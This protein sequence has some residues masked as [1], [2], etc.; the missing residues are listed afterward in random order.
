MAANP[1]YAIVSECLPYISQRLLSDTDPRTGSALRT[2]VFGKDKDR[3]DRVV[4]AERLEL[5]L[6]G[7]GSY[8]QAAGGMKAASALTSQ[9]IEAITE[10]ILDLLLRTTGGKKTP[11]QQLIIDEA[12]KLLGA[13]GRQTWALVRKQSGVLPS[14]RT[15]LGSIVDPLGIFRFSPL[16]L[17]DELDRRILESSLQLVS[18]LQKLVSENSS[19]GGMVEAR[20]DSPQQRELLSR[21]LAK[22]WARRRDL[23][24]LGSGIAAELVVQA[25]RRI[26][27]TPVTALSRSQSRLDLPSSRSP[28][29]LF[30]MTAVDEKKLSDDVNESPRL[31]KARNI[32]V[33]MRDDK[34]SPHA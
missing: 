6:Q 30:G 15:L 16:V 9:Q 5:L 20:L 12:S 21:L 14:G 31:R 24:L 4:D 34:D 1:N 32:V 23:S 13:V 28:V 33:E 26:E 2:F 3:A 10:Q 27:A 19:S 7:F 8:S 11:L 25:I 17:S 29:A 18:L 22:L